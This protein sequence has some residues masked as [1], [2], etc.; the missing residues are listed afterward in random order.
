MS[1]KIKRSIPFLLILTLIVSAVGFGFSFKTSKVEAGTVLPT[2]VVGNSDPV[3]S[4][5]DVPTDPI[6]L[7]ENTTTGVICIATITDSNGGDTISSATA[8]IYRSGV[9]NGSACTASADDCYQIASGSCELSAADG[10]IKYATCTADI[11]FHADPTDTGAYSG[12]TWQCEVTGTDSSSATHSATDASPPNLDTLNALIVTGSV[13]YDTLSPNATSS[14]SKLTVATTTGNASIDVNISGT[15]MD[16]NDTHT[17][18]ISYQEYSL[19][20]VDYG[21]GQD[22]STTATA[23]VL[24]SGKPTTNPSDESDNIY[25]RIGIPS[26]QTPATYYGTTTIAAKAK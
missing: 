24:E 26:G 3:V 17:F 13:D 4:A 5:V 18:S 6:V 10:N 1:K 8:T 12:E 23:L 25:W 9:A 22:A 16:D 19:S 2:V 14:S 7:T 20:E 11:W 21:S 15:D